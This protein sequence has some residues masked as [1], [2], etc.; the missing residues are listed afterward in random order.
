MQQLR[1][2]PAPPKGRLQGIRDQRQRHQQ[3]C[4]DLDE[5]N[6]DAQGRDDEQLLGRPESEQQ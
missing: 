1:K 6:D 2:A 3:L 5:E 4:D